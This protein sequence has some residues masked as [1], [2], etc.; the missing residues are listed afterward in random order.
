MESELKEVRNTQRKIE[1]N[2]QKTKLPTKPATT[3]ETA[4]SSTEKTTDSFC[5][6]SG[7]PS[8]LSINDCDKNSSLEPTASNKSQ[9]T[10][11]ADSKIEY[12]NPIKCKL[13]WK[14]PD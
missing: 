13:I 9:Q 3:K 8:T 5:D 4:F 12:E 2:Y 7:R 1:Q 14:L 6:C 10:A 11:S